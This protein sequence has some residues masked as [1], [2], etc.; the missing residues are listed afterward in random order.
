MAKGLNQKP[1][2]V[3]VSGGFD[4]IHP[5]HIRMFK[6]AKQLGD[7]LVVILNNDNWVMKKKKFVFMHDQERKEVLAAIK[8]VDE[9]VITR[10]PKNPDDMS[11]GA[12]LL[13]IRPDIFANGGDR[14]KGNVPEVEVCRKIGC[15]MVDNVGQ[16]GKIQ[17]SSELVDQAI[18]TAPRKVS[19]HI[20]PSR[21]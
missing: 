21:K 14:H 6:A 1:T 3:A 12:E 8:F 20:K 5:G 15:R 16:G 17:S 18:K 11:V 7:K 2:V 19:I 9:V 4:P 13:R 10:H